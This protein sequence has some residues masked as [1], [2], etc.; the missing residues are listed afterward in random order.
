MPLL[1]ECE[2]NMV[3]LGTEEAVKPLRVCFVCTGN[4]CRSPMA[5]AVTHAIAQKNVASLPESIKAF[6]VPRIEADSAGLYPVQGEPISHGACAALERDGVQP[7]PDHDYH[8][9]RARLLALQQV[10]R[11]DLLVGMTSRHAMELLLRFPQAASKIVCMPE[12]IADPYGGDE[13]AYFTC[14]QQ[15]KKGVQI[16]LADYLL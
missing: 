3:G 14:L 15:I 12:E 9:H 7:T 16:L 11:A 2:R 13:E 5:E 4:T 8:N 6:T 1:M 10:E